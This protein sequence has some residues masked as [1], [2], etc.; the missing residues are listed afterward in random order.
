VP[1]LTHLSRVA[2]LAL[3]LLCV[4]S[5]S[6]SAQAATGVNRTIPYAGYLKDASSGNA[7]PNGQYSIVFKL[8]DVASGGEALWTETQSLITITNGTF[9]VVLGSV[10]TFPPGVDFNTDN[11]YL[12]MAVGTG[13]E[14][15]PRQRLGAA[16]YSM[17]ADTTDGIHITSGTAGYLPKFGTGGLTI[18]G[19]S[20]LYD[21][22]TGKVG[23][24]TTTPGNKLE[25]VGSLTLSLSGTL[26][27]GIVYKDT[28]PSSYP[29]YSLELD[30][31]PSLTNYTDGTSLQFVSYNPTTGNYHWPLLMKMDRLTDSSVVE[32][33]KYTAG[34]ATM[35]LGAKTAAGAVGVSMVNGGAGDLL[36][37]GSGK[38][39]VNASG[40]VGIGTTTPTNGLLEISNSTGVVGAYIGSNV[41]RTAPNLRLIGQ[42]GNATD[43]GGGL[44]IGDGSGTITMRLARKSD[45]SHY[46]YTQGSGLTLSLG[47]AGSNLS[48]EMKFLDVAPRS[49]GVSG[50]YTNQ[51]F[52]MFETPNLTGSGTITNGA[53]V[54]IAGAPSTTG[55]SITNPY[56]LWIDSGTTRYDSDVQ[57]AVD[58]GNV[59]IGTAS[60]GAKLE[61]AGNANVTGTLRIGPD[62]SKGIITYSTNSLFF[63]SGSSALGMQLSLGNLALGQ[64]GQSYS[65]SISLMNQGAGTDYNAGNLTFISGRGTGAGTAGSFVFQTA[66]VQGSGS[67][68]QTIT[69]KMVLL[70]NGNVG[71]GTTSPLGT[72][73]VIGNVYIRPIGGVG[74]RLHLYNP[75]STNEAF[76]RDVGA[77]GQS[78]LVF[79][80]S[81][82]EVMRIT[83]NGV[84]GTGNVGIGTTTPGSKLDV[85]AGSVTEGVYTS[86]IN[87]G[88][89]GG[90]TQGSIGTR[91]LSSNSRQGLKIFAPASLTLNAQTYDIDFQTGTVTN[92]TGDAN[93]VMKIKN[94]GN[95]GIGTTAPGQALEVNGGV[96]V[97]T[98]TA[99]PTC[100]AAA[101]GTLWMT[102]GAS[103][104]KDAIEMCA[105]DAS[106]AYVW[107]VLD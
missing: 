99:K 79:E 15:S 30:H 68:A 25:V 32:F 18:G 47:G 41:T 104:V 55:P 22:G 9:A 91:Y 43:G 51:R 40:N 44:E 81:G 50:S 13:A 83:N 72:L 20:S 8:Y 80:P 12:T 29:T 59:G 36:D 49:N 102:Q 61:V 58:S 64:V 38:L 103:G 42:S 95:V 3:A 56:A 19:S 78:A 73:D 27:G 74:S 88:A 97:N 23:I 10:T 26:P 87:I 34:I 24:G 66:D 45:N 98:A 57:M 53:T 46:I 21:D 84:P 71:I 96:R 65:E 5:I 48:T 101:R 54:Y 60:P 28:S 17:N 77:S 89:G 76:I 33:N 92:E 7:A 4:V 63:G 93:T 35:W 100:N 86:A 107:R 31:R 67:T 75:S 39:R 94:N 6:A 105:K 82:N 37:V 52:T 70:A 14:M 106:D 90:A 62:S 69:T 11:L 2:A 85:Y 1:S 16:P